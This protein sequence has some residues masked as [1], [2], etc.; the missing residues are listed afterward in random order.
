MLD[1]KEPT[2][3]TST[4]V[5]HWF[6]FKVLALVGKVGFERGKTLDTSRGAHRKNIWEGMV[7]TTEVRGVFTL[8][9]DHTLQPK[10][11]EIPAR[12]WVEDPTSD[13]QVKR[14]QNKQQGRD[15]KMLNF[16][17]SWEHQWQ[18]ETFVSERHC[19]TS[20]S[21]SSQNAATEKLGSPRYRTASLGLYC[22]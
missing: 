8:N 2:L 12:C 11:K 17:K 5:V 9:C 7:F 21:I 16:C 6:I 14:S 19:V 4:R 13:S 18:W 10:S 20:A 15:P 3:P 22:L 1:W